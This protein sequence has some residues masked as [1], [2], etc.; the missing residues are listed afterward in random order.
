MDAIQM[1]RA[2]QGMT[3]KG[4]AG[5]AGAVIAVMISII[6]IVA[7]ALP[8]TQSVLYTQTCFNQSNTSICDPNVTGATATVLN[9]LPLF[10]G[11]AALVTIA[12]LFA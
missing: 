5:A 10:L 11:L 2:A 1:W 8:V 9:L 4:F 7:V 12:A 6:I 3:R